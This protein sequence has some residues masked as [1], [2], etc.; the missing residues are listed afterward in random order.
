M[1]IKC[2]IAWIAWMLFL[3]SMTVHSE[4]KGNVK[5]VDVKVLGKQFVVLLMKEDFLNATKNFDSTMKKAMPADKLRQIWKGLIAQVGPFKNQKSVRTEK[6]QE[7]DLVFVTCQFEKTTLDIKVVFNTAHQ[8]SG[9]WFVTT[10]PAAEYKEPSYVKPAFYSE[11]KTVVGSGEWSL[12]GTLTM[13]F[14]GSLFPAVVL[15]HG[16]GP[17][18]RDETIGPNKPFRDLALG[19]ASHGIAV[20]RYEKRTKE[21]LA[22]FASMGYNITP[23][24][25]TTDDALAAVSILRKTPG[26]DPKKIFILGHSLGGMLVPKIASIDPGITGFIIMAGNTRPMEDVLLEQMMYIFSL[27]G[28]IN[29][30]EEKKLA[31]VK[32]QIAKIKDPKLNLLSTETLLGVPAKYWLYLRSYNPTGIAKNLKQPILILQGGRDYQVTMKDFQ[33]WKNA[34]STHKNVAFKLYPN[35]NHLFSH[36]KGKSTPSEYEIPGNVS[37]MVINDIVAWIKSIK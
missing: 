28:T 20:L 14:E 18:D 17:Q 11:K 33:N 5:P 15:V 30:D 22:K 35:L 25:E 29:K 3:G 31:Q 19:L 24:E 23:K 16:S 8:I 13:P 21:H 6:Y 12:P 7:F 9:M 2:V 27:D 10:P 26:I 34:L 4:E 37:E 32:T 1:K 36:G